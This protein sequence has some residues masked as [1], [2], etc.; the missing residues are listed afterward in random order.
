MARQGILAK[1]KPSAGTNTLLY[2]AP[3][4]S[5]ASTVLNV[6]AQ[7]G[8]NTTFDVALKNYDQKLVVDASTHLLHEGDV[9]TGYRF[10]L[11]TAIPA[12]AGL[13]SGTLLTSSDAESTA[14]FESF[15]LPAFTEIDVRVRAI[16]A[17]TL[18]S[19]SGT[20]AVGETIVKGTSPNTATATIYSVSQGSGSTIVYVGPS[21]LAGTGTEFADGDA[22]TASGGATGTISTGGIATATNDFTFQ[23]QGGTESLYLGDSLTLFTD[24]A[25]RFDVSD[26]TMSGRDFKL[27]ITVNGEYGPDNDFTQTT[28]NGVEY[29][30]GKTTN[31][32]AG[33]TGAYVQYDLSQ[34]SGL[35]QNLYYYDGGTGTASNSDYGGTDRLLTV[36]TSYEYSEIYVYDVDG[37]W[38][39]NVDGFEFN[40]TTY[41]VSSQTSGPYG[42][43]RSYS[44]TDLYII[45]GVGSADF[46]G[47][48]TFQDNPKEGGGDRGTVTVSSV[49][50]AVTAFETQEVI[51]KDNAITANT[52]EEIKSLVIGPGERL[53]V[54]NAAADCSFV[55]IGFEDAS[56]GFTTRTYSATA[57]AGAAS[58][59]G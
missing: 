39:N 25:Y 34:D 14:R 51:R 35:N 36:S 56:T 37:T 50:V 24:R 48:D 21:T 30:T 15:Y 27:S 1:A 26:S 19:V 46:A 4:D 17:I 10:A 47:S 58:G 41:T 45:K 44:G 53:I 49:A 38:T 54:E 22:L 59:G 57:V 52:T 5:S 11:S 40:G 18:E 6:T 7:G 20:L 32:T 28:D 3:I 29:T 2:S 42:Y 16:R 8:S 9:V 33:S 31:G 43:V 23:E 55:L 13:A 12:T